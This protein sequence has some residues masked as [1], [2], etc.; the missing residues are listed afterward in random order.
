MNLNQLHEMWEKD[1]DID[2]TSIQQESRKTFTLH[3][4]YHRLLSTERLRLVGMEYDIKKI[5][6]DLRKSLENYEEVPDFDEVKL[7]Y[8]IAKDRNKKIPKSEITTTVD[9][10]DSVKTLTMNIA[11]AKEKVQFLESVIKVI[12]GRSFDLKNIIEQNKYESGA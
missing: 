5:K 2:L 4:K 3:S 8:L 7:S 11:M 9:L 1:C 12:M 10:H 6:F